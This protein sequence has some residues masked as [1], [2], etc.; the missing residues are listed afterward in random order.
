MDTSAEG[1]NATLPGPP[2]VTAA[3][4][5]TYLSG[6][7]LRWSLRPSRFAHVSSIIMSIIEDNKK[8]GFL[9]R[10]PPLRRLAVSNRKSFLLH[11]YKYLFVAKSGLKNFPRPLSLEQTQFVSDNLNDENI[12][13]IEDMI[14]ISK[15]A[16][17]W[18]LQLVEFLLYN[19]A[20][21]R[22]NISVA[23]ITICRQFL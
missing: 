21:C 11:F 18:L 6:R 2:T 19:V 3:A 14:E 16:G 22:W 10:A 13:C 20:G 4:S 5:S 7:K 17:Y 1:T 8:L 23:A 9:R 15:T 12:I